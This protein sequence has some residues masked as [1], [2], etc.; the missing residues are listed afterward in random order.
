MKVRA[1][2]LRQPP[3]CPSRRDISRSARPNEARTN[4]AYIDD[5]PAVSR[6]HCGQES[7]CEPSG[8]KIRDRHHV[9]NFF[10]GGFVKKLPLAAKPGIVDDDIGNGGLARSMRCAVAVT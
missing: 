4:R 1:Q 6:A 2:G 5:M 10:R 3:Y 7:A 9:L 8:G